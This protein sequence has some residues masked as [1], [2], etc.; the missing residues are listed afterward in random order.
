MWKTAVLKLIYKIMEKLSVKTQLILL[1][2]NC[3]KIA[4]T[5]AVALKYSLNIK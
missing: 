1:Y 4:K 3:V 2:L 5:L